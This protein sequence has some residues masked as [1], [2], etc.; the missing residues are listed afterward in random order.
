MLDWLA[1]EASTQNPLRT[2]D[3]GFKAGYDAIAYGCHLGHQGKVGNVPGRSGTPEDEARDIVSTLVQ[4]GLLD[5]FEVCDEWTFEARISGWNDDVNLP[6]EAARK[7]KSPSTQGNPATSSVVPGRPGTSQTSPVVPERPPT[8]QDKTV[9]A[10]S[11]TPVADAKESEKASDD[12]KHLCGLL[13]DLIRNRDPRFKGKP[14]SAGWLREM[15]LLVDEREGDVAQ[16][17]RVIRWVQADS[18][19]QSNVMSPKKLRVQ[20]TQLLDK[21]AK[22]NVRRLPVK[23]MTEEERQRAILGDDTD[24]PEPFFP[25][26]EAGL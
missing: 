18:F 14:T 7:R 3:G 11:T 13:S 1:L 12:V 17:E 10:S 25:D 16:V 24:L 22:D 4:I 20:F 9:K 6:I 8:E 5:D 2:G 21:A 26:H 23:A 15:R 19:W